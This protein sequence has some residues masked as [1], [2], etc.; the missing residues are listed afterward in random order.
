MLVS[1]QLALVS[2][3][4]QHG[5]VDADSLHLMQLPTCFNKALLSSR[6]QLASVARD[7]SLALSTTL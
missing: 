7:A 4:W 2:D 1:A 6:H 3:V 5:A